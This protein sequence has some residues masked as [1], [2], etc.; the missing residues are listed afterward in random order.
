MH[1]LVPTFVDRVADIFEIFS[2]DRA[3][4]EDLDVVFDSNQFG[5]V[6][7]RLSGELLALRVDMKTNGGES[8]IGFV[9]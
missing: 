5:V 3:N 4:E 6:D 8:E 2:S 7:P 9:L 1:L